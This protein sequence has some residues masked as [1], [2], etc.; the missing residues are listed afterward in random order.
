MGL[1][2]YFKSFVADEARAL[3]TTPEALAGWAPSANAAGRATRGT[4][5]RSGRRR[6][7]AAE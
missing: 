5:R 7:E 6:G 2:D 4:A 3:D 1:G